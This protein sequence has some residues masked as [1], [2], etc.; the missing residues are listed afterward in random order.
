M[1]DCDLSNFGCS[2]GYLVS[3]ILHLIDEGTVTE[4][5]NPYTDKYARCTFRCD[6]NVEYKRY[7][8][9]P[10]SLALPTRASDIQRHLMT[11]GPMM[12]GLSVYEDFLSFKS[13]VY[14]YTAGRMV[15]GHAMKLIGWG[16]AENGWK[17]WIL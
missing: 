17:Y 4:S 12:V 11:R 7:Y 6:G 15:G 1:V 3:A 14:H 9:K 16:T 5:C 13:G 2:G 8:C 10:G